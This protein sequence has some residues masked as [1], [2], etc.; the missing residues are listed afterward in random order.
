MY[1][2]LNVLR[3]ECRAVQDTR[4]SAK[5]AVT[6]RATILGLGLPSTRTV[7]LARNIAAMAQKEVKA[8][9]A[10]DIDPENRTQRN[11][12]TS[13]APERNP[14]STAAARRTLGR[15][16]LA[17][18]GSVTASAA[19]DCSAESGSSRRRRARIRKAP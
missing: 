8:I 10:S 15:N 14:Q 16:R 12:S 2:S 19:A 5:A 6:A 7:A 18:C 13:R 9:E 3:T 17:S 4:W 1:S 11:M